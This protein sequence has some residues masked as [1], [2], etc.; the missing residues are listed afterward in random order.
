M[1]RNQR[2]SQHGR[3]NAARE[4]VRCSEE[5]KMSWLA[6]V[7][8]LPR[9]TLCRFRPTALGSRP[10][11]G[12]ARSRLPVPGG[13]TS[14]G[15]SRQAADPAPGSSPPP[16]HEQACKLPS[17]GASLQ[18][19]GCSASRMCSALDRNH[20]QGFHTEA[21]AGGV[22]RAG[23]LELGPETSRTRSIS[24]TSAKLGS[25]CAPTLRP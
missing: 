10:L 17:P 13:R 18:P 7:S 5:R 11:L 23:W 22:S 12:P 4:R 3:S 2:M 21:G 6:G 8:T 14:F 20:A 9:L 15:V 25:R 16:L 1:W 19:R 24:S